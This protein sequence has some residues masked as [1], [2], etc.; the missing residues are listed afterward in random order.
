MLTISKYLQA[1]TGSPSTAAVDPE[2]QL[3]TWQCRCGDRARYYTLDECLDGARAHCLTCRK[4]WSDKPCDTT[5]A[6][7]DRA[8]IVSGGDKGGDK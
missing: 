6:R 5:L 1:W 3:Y 2:P 7:P 4:W 8:P